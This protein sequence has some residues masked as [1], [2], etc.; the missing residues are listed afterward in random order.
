ME[1]VK[2]STLRGQLDFVTHDKPV[3][4]SEVEPASEIVKRFATGELLGYLES[5][6][7]LWNRKT[8]MKLKFLMGLCFCL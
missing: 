7:C 6:K 2:Y 1:S 5:T 3:D 8:L 4:I